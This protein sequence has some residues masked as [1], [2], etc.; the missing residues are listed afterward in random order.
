MAKAIEPF[1]LQQVIGDWKAAPQGHKTQAVA[2][3]AKRLGIATETLYK[4]IPTGRVRR[5]GD[6]IIK[7]IEDAAA[8][9]AAIKRRPPEHRGEI[10][11][12]DAVKIALSNGAL[13]ESYA[14]V[15][16]SS[17]DRT[18]RDMGMNRRQRRIV[19]YQAERPNQLHHVD[20]SSSKCFYVKEALPD[21]DFVLR[22][23][24][25]IAGYKNKPV[26][27]R[28]RPWIY[29][30]TDDYSG[31]HVARMI[32]ALGESAGDNM[33]FLSWAWSQNADSFLFGLP[34]SI[35]GDQGPMMKSDGAP[36]WFGRLGV[37]MD[38]SIAMNKESHG[39]IERPWR[40]MWERFELPFFV[41]SNWKKFEI[42]LSELN[43]R[44]MLYQE[45]YNNKKHR[46]ERTIT[47][48]QAWHKISLYGGATALPENA[49]RTAV[50]RWQ[51]T[52][53]TAGVFSIDNVLYEV[54]G[55][56]DAK[57]WFYQGI[58]EDMMMV[59]DQR[60][61]AKYEVESFVPNKVGEYTASADTPHQT[62]V[63]AARELDGLTNTLYTEKTVRAANVAQFPTKIK[64]TR[65]LEN[66]LDM[67]RMQSLEAALREFQTVCG[68]I[69]PREDRETVS[70]LIIE[71][72]LSRK[73]V[74]N[75][76]LEIQAEQFERR[77]AV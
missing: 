39:K 71:N 19:R 53:D 37:E 41:E 51:R 48:S 28:L 30:L 22:L 47:R 24:P 56:H 17:F 44:F 75:L 43:R 49:I 36:E 42:T 38:G 60:D 45:E 27:I 52:V 18:M 14:D 7:G 46:F 15:S 55:L 65:P 66:P 10:T 73:Y 20:A 29:G 72:G 32:A 31:V 74:V 58:F 5:K 67:D 59:V 9:I 3:W 34:E 69:L 6:R 25:G 57:V 13:S 1:I 40:T 68:F 63:K 70:S 4:A 26:P 33:D 8:T 61:G 35:K 11:T 2:D 16:I 62:A 77:Y 21:G 12:A 50:R 76:A 23:H 64:E 54:K